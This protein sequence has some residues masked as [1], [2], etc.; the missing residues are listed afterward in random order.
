MNSRYRGK[1][2]VKLL[3]LTNRVYNF[4]NNHRETKKNG[5]KTTY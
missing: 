3:N 1:T 5:I 2:L 4:N